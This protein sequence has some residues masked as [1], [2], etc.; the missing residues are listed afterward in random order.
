MARRLI[1]TSL[2]LLLLL[3]CVSLFDAMY[4][5]VLP[6]CW[7]AGKEERELGTG[8]CAV[9]IFLS[10]SQS[11]CGRER[12][13]VETVD[14]MAARSFYGGLC[15]LFIHWQSPLGYSKDVI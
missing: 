3:T 1:D 5:L 9:L 6:Q 4:I 13:R 11:V 2:Q 12:K 8:C 15:L 14:K 10:L 7:P